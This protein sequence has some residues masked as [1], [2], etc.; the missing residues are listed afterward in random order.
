M[1]EGAGG[2]RTRRR[3]SFIVLRNGIIGNLL[4]HSNLAIYGELA[5]QINGSH[6][7]TGGAISPLDNSGLP[8]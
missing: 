3:L 1:Q 4:P 8:E 7:A 5:C 6:T 2:V